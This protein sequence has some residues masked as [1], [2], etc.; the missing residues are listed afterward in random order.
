MSNNGN[1]SQETSVCFDVS[2]SGKNGSIL[3]PVFFQEYFFQF[4]YLYSIYLKRDCKN[5][6]KMFKQLNWW[7]RQYI[8]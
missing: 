7:F 4:N 1:V 2:Q 3:F 8:I 6:R 5:S